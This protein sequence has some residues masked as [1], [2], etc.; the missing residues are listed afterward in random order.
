MASVVEGEGVAVWEELKGRCTN[1]LAM[2]QLDVRLG[3]G[4]I[5]EGNDVARGRMLLEDVAKGPHEVPAKMAAAVL[6]RLEPGV[7]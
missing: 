4:Y 2:A 5:V 6:A 3:E 1:P 7:R